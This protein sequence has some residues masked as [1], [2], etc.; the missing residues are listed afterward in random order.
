MVIGTGSSF[1]TDRPR[2]RRTASDSHTIHGTPNDWQS[3]S[4]TPPPVPNVPVEY[5]RP[6]Q[7]QL[8]THG[9]FFASTLLTAVGSQGNEG[10][11]DAMQNVLG[12]GRAELEGMREELA[13]C[14]DKWRLEKGMREVSLSGAGVDDQMVSGPVGHRARTDW[15]RSPHLCRRPRYASRMP[16]S[17]RRQARTVLHHAA[18]C[19]TNPP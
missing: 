15:S 16:R 13:G 4:P 10:L 17:S 11:A 18:I 12:L 8:S 1:P 7:T 14:Y 5:R 9:H 3:R 6:P 2:P 19:G